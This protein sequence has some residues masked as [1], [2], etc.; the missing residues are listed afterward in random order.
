M[1][2]QL[3]N[4]I[5]QSF[6]EYSQLTV[7]EIYCLNYSD[8]NFITNIF[9]IY[10]ESYNDNSIIVNDLIFIDLAD[11]FNQN[12]K[13]Y[14]HNFIYEYCF[15]S[16]IYFKEDQS[17]LLKFR[18]NIDLYKSS[19]IFFSQN[20]KNNNYEINFKGQCLEYNKSNIDYIISHYI[21]HITEKKLRS[22]TM[23]SAIVG[24]IENKTDLCQFF[25]VNLLS[26]HELQINEHGAEDNI[27]YEDKIVIIGY[28]HHNIYITNLK[29]NI[30]YKADLR[31]ISKKD[32]FNHIIKPLKSL[33]IDINKKSKIDFY[34]RWKDTIYEEIEYI[35]PTGGM[36]DIKIKLYKPEP[37]CN[38]L[39]KTIYSQRPLIEIS[40]II[41]N[42]IIWSLKMTNAAYIYKKYII[43]GYQYYK[44]LSNINYD[45]I[46]IQNS[47]NIVESNNQKRRI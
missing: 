33:L 18:L 23:F 42:D 36:K 11:F 16:N 29:S 17:L 8:N 21:S 5:R 31:K 6:P 45:K 19:Y 37:E 7:L 9:N 25:N 22:G 3:K 30:F 35:L 41:N 20:I 44:T 47:M 32:F 2:K 14:I 1:N 27:D 4:Y 24:H 13:R 34:S 43:E 28:K 15:Q 46:T 38:F 10:S 39:N 26:E 40:F 12:K